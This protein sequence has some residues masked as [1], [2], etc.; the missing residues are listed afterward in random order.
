MVNKVNGVS[1]QSA[2]VTIFDS[3]GKGSVE[4]VEYVDYSEACDSLEDKLRQR[5]A[6]GG[7]IRDIV[8]EHF[9]EVKRQL[10]AEILVQLLSTLL[11][12]SDIKLDLEILVSAA[13]IGLREQ[14]DSVIAQRFGMIRQTFSARK[15]ALLKKLNLTP[16]AH[17][18][19]KT[20]CNVYKITNRKNGT[21]K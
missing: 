15:K 20:A 11:D 8:I 17:S 6:D 7:D 2:H 16:P 5:L 3:Q 18:K 14:P 4:G 19:S 1:G 21:L 9:G 12:S 13:G 10:L